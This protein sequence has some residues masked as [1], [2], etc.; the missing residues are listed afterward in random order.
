MSYSNPYQSPTSAPQFAIDADLT[1]R[2]GFIRNTYFHLTMAI[3]ALIGLEFAAFSLFS[4]QLESFAKFVLGGQYIWLGLLV[5]FMV[6]SWV[7]DRWA[8]SGGSLGLQYLGL[9][10]YVVAQAVILAPLLYIASTFF[11]GAIQ[12]AAV[13]TGIVFIALTAFVFLTRTD[14]SFLRN[15]LF[16]AGL[17]AICGLLCLMFL[18]SFMPGVDF[19]IMHLAFTIGMIALA[20]GY[21]LYH[22]SNVLHHYRT[23]QYVAAS[24]ALFSSVALLF[25]YILRLVMAARE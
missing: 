17:A 5:G 1:D 12:T 6:V 19:S 23:D 22:T 13:A 2:L 16:V 10:L 14:F 18:P 11:P 15:V 24:L 3:L 4:E 7:A 8:L 9:S 20:S 25:W 21:I